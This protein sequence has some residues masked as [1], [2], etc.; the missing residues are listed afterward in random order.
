MIIHSDKEEANARRKAEKK[1][2]LEAEQKRRQIEQ[3]E[4]KKIYEE[5][6]A[7]WKKK[8]DEIA[9]KRNQWVN[10]RLVE[11]SS[12]NEKCIEN[13]YNLDKKRIEDSLCLAKARL[14]MLQDNSSN[15][16]LKKENA[17][18]IQ[19]TVS[20]TKTNIELLTKDLSI[21]TA[22]YTQ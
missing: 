14:A 2:V 7:I 19:N 10:D 18:K 6:Y 13:A 9:P 4:K 17:I 1:A 22:K 12:Y 11:E 5:E 8:Y 3:N 16:C 20:Q 21:A 15:S